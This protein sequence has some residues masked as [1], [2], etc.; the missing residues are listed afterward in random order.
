MAPALEIL[1]QRSAV[2]VAGVGGRGSAAN[3]SFPKESAWIL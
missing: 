3:T 1:N 2:V